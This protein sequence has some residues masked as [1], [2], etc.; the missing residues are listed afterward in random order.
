MIANARL[1]GPV[2][3][4]G[5]HQ[6][7]DLGPP[8]Q[9]AVFAALA[10]H[11]NQV[12]SREELVDAVWGTDAPATA[13]NSVYTYVARLRNR[14][15]PAR[16]QRAR[17]GLLVS[18]G[19][20]YMLR[21][22]P[23]QVDKQRFEAH[24]SLARQ[25][26]RTNAAHRAIGE[27]EAG[28]A[29]WQG[30]AYGGAVGPF[31]EADRTRLTELRLA[32]ME[33]RAEMLLELERHSDVMGELFGLVRQHPR[34]ERL[35]YL[36]MLCYVRLGR[37]T[38]A[39]NEYHDLRTTLADELGI[40]PGEALQRFYTQILR[41]GPADWPLAARARARDPHPD[42]GGLAQL[43][44]DVPSFIGRTA[45]LARLDELATAAGRA[46]ESGV[47][48]LA[49][50][51]AMGKSALAV[52]FA[53]T[54]APRFP[55][56]QLHIDLRGFDRSGRPMAAVEALGHLLAALGEPEQPVVDLERMR[57]RYRGLTAGRK[58]LILLDNA[59]SADQVRPLLPAT[60]RCV[61]LVTSRN[62][63][64]GLTVRDDARRITVDA[65]DEDDAVSLF[66]RLVRQPLDP[67]NLPAVRLLAR[68]AGCV[69]LALRA[70]AARVSAAASPADALA[71]LTA[72]Q[73]LDPLDVPG[74]DDASVRT[75]F[76]WSYRALTDA[77]AAMFRALGRGPEPAFTLSAAAALAGCDPC[78]ARRQ[79]DALADAHLVTEPVPD[80][81]RLNPLVLAYARRLTMVEASAPV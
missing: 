17:S 35:R 27:L 37:Q 30:T 77:T 76:D 36:L 23:G 75:V 1:L 57:A 3:A 19:S 7:I 50:G 54:V 4:Y 67:A 28:L 16:S 32:A 20:G 42:R 46:H 18:D 9:R 8:R 78:R 71:R 79:L 59:A 12:V 63:L 45:E 22:P 31:V 6:E 14:L 68:R 73:L 56:G 41:R 53:H 49:G 15:E 26:H 48:L 2:T 62:G 72:S 10:A 13:M 34:R 40:E 58:L 51:P 60:P 25:Q 74:D 69:P 38:D 66:V 70:A 47:F 24:L 11:A 80:L 5:D 29:L 55:D 64:A 21:L 81:F 52:R 61:V 33:D 39:L 44:R 43:A 65:L